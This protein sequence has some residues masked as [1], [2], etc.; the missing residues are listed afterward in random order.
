MMPGFHREQLKGAPLARL[1]GRIS[2]GRFQVTHK[3]L[4]IACLVDIAKAE[5]DA[6]DF[7][8]ACHDFAF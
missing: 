7:L 2:A 4:R 1:N 3:R 5:T 8:F 6:S